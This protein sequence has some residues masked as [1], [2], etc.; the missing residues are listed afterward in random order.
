MQYNSYQD[1]IY[2]RTYSRWLED[3]NRRE[4]WAETV[5]RYADFFYSS[6]PAQLLPDYKAAID[7]ILLKEVMP[8]MRALWAAGPALEREH[9]AGYNCAAT[10]IDRPEVFG[11]ILYILMNGTGVGFSVERQFINKLPDVPPLSP[12]DHTI[13]FADSKEGWAQGYTNL[14]E[15]LYKGFIP[16]YDLSNIRPKGAPLRVF[17]GRASGPEPLKH[18]IVYTIDLFTRC[19]GRK[20]NSIECHDLVCTIANC[21]IVGGVR[22]SATISLSNFSDMRMR[23][24]KDGHFYIEH[25]ERNLANNSV[26]YTEKPDM[27]SFMEEWL[28]LARSGSGERGIINRVSMKQSAANCGRDSN[29]EFVVNPCGEVI[30]RPQGLCNLTEVVI[31]AEDSLESIFN[32]VKYATILGV[33]QATLTK[34]GFVGKEWIKNAEEER[35]LGVSL[36]GICDNPFFTTPSKE[37]EEV[38]TK[39]R[40]YSREVANEWADALGIERP[41]AITTVKPSGTVSQLVN[42]SSGIHPR[43]SNYY[44]RRVRVT[45]TDPLAKYLEEMGVNWYPEVG[46]THESHNTKVFEFPIA[47]PKDC[48]TRHSVSAIDQLELWKLYKVYWTDH[49]PSCT[50]YVD[51]DE[52][53]AV[54][55]WVYKNWDIIGGL[56]FLPKDG[57]IYPLAPYEEITREE[58]EEYSSKFPLLN[59]NDLYKY[60]KKDAT[61]GARE[62]A[63]VGGVCEL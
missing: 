15:T 17:G 1:F 24:A 23:H 27:F 8:S 60:E 10:A 6:V 9:L 11:E 21:V 57:G 20:L 36:T 43:Y 48:V 55:D 22:R 33:L 51:E 58:Y 29:F 47:S 59:F 39:L 25:P 45:A 46:E 26:A 37:L 4:M 34:F 2:T 49:N 19:Q 28:A 42:S 41:R 5:D 52:W 50:I 56:S 30:L 62:W 38:L 63:C 61:Q 12:I 18:L 54:G 44:L 35:L 16:S 53:F 3:K 13:I 14:V 32:K 40:S 7:H 31:R